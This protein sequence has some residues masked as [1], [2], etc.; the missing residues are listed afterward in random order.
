[1][2]ANSLP[3]DATANV[4][5]IYAALRDDV[6]QGSSTVADFQHAVMLTKLIGDVFASSLAG[7]RLLAAGWPER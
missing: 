3:P 7:N 2:K 1:M 6:T 5:G 4:A